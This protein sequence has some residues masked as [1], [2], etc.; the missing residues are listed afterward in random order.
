MNVIREVVPFSLMI[1]ITGLVSTTIL[2]KLDD[3]SKK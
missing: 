2:F 3:K 1:V